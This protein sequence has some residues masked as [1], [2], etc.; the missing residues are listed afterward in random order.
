M[1]IYISIYIQYITKV[2]YFGQHLL[3]IISS[4]MPVVNI[5]CMLLGD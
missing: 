4:S 1:L 2:F 3:E 5:I